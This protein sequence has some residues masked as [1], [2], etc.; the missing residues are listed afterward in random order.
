NQRLANLI[1]LSRDAVIIRDPAHHILFW[2]Q[3]AERLYGWTEQEASGKEIHALLSTRFPVSLEEV[4]TLLKENGQWEGIL[5]HTCQDGEM[6]KVES[7][8]VLVRNEAGEVSDILEINRDVTE[9]ERLARERAEAKANELILRE[10]NRLMDEFIGIAGHELRT[11]L[12]TIKVSVQLAQRQLSRMLKQY[13][14]QDA[15]H[16]TLS[17]L[18]DHLV[19]TEKQISMQNRLISDL[20]DVS[21]IHAGRME[22]H[23]DL[24]DLVS[25]VQE[26]VGDQ[27]YLTPERTLDLVITT[28]EQTLVMADADRVRQVVSNYISNALKYSEATEPVKIRVRLIDSCVQVSVQDHGPGLSLEQQQRVWERFYRVPSVEVKAGSGIGLGLG[29]H[30]SRMIIEWQ[31]GQV[32]VCSEPGAGSTFWFTLPL[33]EG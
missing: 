7:Q 17:S 33:A 25:L 5:L 24:C 10:A 12:T 9:R 14:S 32:G 2:N 31:Q 27:H 22:L 4:S 19:R 3:G 26:V 16:V 8:Q 1:E 11:P 21:R 18:R 20:L 30:I 23:P 13:A 29:L 28:P 15:M 6:V